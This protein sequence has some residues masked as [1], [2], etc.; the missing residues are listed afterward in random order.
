MKRGE[1]WWYESPDEP[2]RPWVIL[3]RDEAID[4]LTK[5]LAAPA[6][7]TIRGTAPRGK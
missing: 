2:P 4:R 3:T 7:R 1:V 6:T 5:I